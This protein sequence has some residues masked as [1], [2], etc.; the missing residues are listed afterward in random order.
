MSNFS[1]CALFL[2]VSSHQYA[3][4]SVD[5][6]TPFAAFTVTLRPSGQNS[7]RFVPSK[8]SRVREISFMRP[9]PSLAQYP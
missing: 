4:I 9:T 3:S 8:F 5:L 1:V 7:K 6:P 2:P